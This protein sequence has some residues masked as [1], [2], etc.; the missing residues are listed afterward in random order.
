MKDYE[1]LSRKHFDK[2]A[3][4]YDEKNTY[5]YSR[6]GKISCRDITRY[7][8]EKNI[9][10]ENL[11]DV[12]TGTGY[13]IDML[14]RKYEARFYGLDLSEN[15]IMQAKAKHI[16]NSEFI[17]GKANKLPFNDSS[18]DVVTCSQSFHHYPYQ[19][20]AMNE[21]YRV[22]KPGGIYILS[23]TGIGGIGA[24]I[25][26]NIIFKLMTSGDCHTTNRYG[27][28][29]LM[30]EAKFDLIDSYKVQGMVYTVIGKK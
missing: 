22:L 28:E 11:L 3:K 19:L 9:R 5:Y 30:R 12:G 14:S 2:Q 17:V 10:F 23:D 7:L 13:L 24:W 21:A 8:E 1:D 26:N 29:K 20:D 6:E 27:I 25:D 4:D 15:M 18:F 16:K